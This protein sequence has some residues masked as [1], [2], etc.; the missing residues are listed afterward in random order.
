MIFWTLNIESLRV[1]KEEFS[2]FLI[3]LPERNG[4]QLLSLDILCRSW[5]VN[6]CFSFS[7][8]LLPIDLPWNLDQHLPTWL[9]SGHMAKETKRILAKAQ[10]KFTDLKQ[11]YWTWDYLKHPALF[12]SRTSLSECLQPKSCSTDQPHT[13]LTPQ[14]IPLLSSEHHSLPKTLKCYISAPNYSKHLD[15]KSITT[16]SWLTAVLKHDKKYWAEEPLPLNLKM[17]PPE[18]PPKAPQKRIT[19][20]QNPAHTEDAAQ[21]WSSCHAHFPPLVATER[22]SPFFRSAKGGGWSLVPSLTSPAAFSLGAFSSSFPP[23]ALLWSERSC[24]ITPFIT[25]PVGSG[26]DSD[27]STLDA[28]MENQTQSDLWKRRRAGK[29]ETPNQ[30]L[31]SWMKTGVC[32]A[33]RP[34]I[35]ISNI[36]GGGFRI[37][38]CLLDSVHRAGWVCITGCSAG[39]TS[40]HKHQIS[41]ESQGCCEKTQSW[42]IRLREHLNCSKCRTDL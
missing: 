20:S 31:G 12:E 26:P 30:P 8:S 16:T 11:I 15:A 33:I 34:Q 40:N 22:H 32:K 10:A 14:Q 27:C 41:A 17:L 29:N 13:T 39:W 3:Q 42:G 9:V 1:H 36:S 28:Q 24:L 25:V 7:I 37:C 21:H 6:G 23:G 4:K 18:I 5:M 19:M 35:C 38:Y 2:S